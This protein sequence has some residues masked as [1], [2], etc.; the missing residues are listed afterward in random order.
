MALASKVARAAVWSAVRIAGSQVTSFLVFMS[1]TR[2]LAPEEIGLMALAAAVID[3]SGPLT[4][5]GFPESLIQR[6]DA[7]ELQADTCFWTTLLLSLAM[8]GLVIV[9]APYAARAFDAPALGPVLQVSSVIL[10]LV[11][12]GAT[13]EARLTRDFGHKALAMRGLVAN[14]FGGGVGIGM[15]L[16]GFGVWSL[17]AQRIVST[18]AAVLFAWWS[19]RWVPK[20]RFSRVEFSRMS[21]FGVHMVGISFLGTLNGRILDFLLGYFAGAAAVGHVRV[22]SRCLDM[23]TQFTVTPLTSVALPA[24]S[25]LQSDPV[26]FERGFRRMVRT[27]ALVTFPSYLGLAAVADDLLPLLFGSQW[28]VSATVL[29]IM[30]LG[31]IPITLHAFTWTSIVAVGRSDRAALGALINV[32]FTALTVALAAPFGPLAAVAAN[33]ARAYVGL[34]IGFRFLRVNT[35]VRAWP[36]FTST[37]LPMASAVIMSASVWAVK[38]ATAE[39]PAIVR[40]ACMVTAGALVYSG[41]MWTL[42]QQIVIEMRDVWQRAGAK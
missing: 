11:A 15:G 34:P 32:S 7:N 10:P 13:H 27:C 39:M 14:V 25:R 24:F 17:V 3:L 19:Y 33:V 9:S 37:L 41:V 35:G 36:L 29:Q 4:R 26:A 8:A 21:R 23:V 5:A 22:A 16:M 28:A 20:L 2:L 38:G 18:L 42:G 31:V 30:C 40:L 1:L 12:L 6:D